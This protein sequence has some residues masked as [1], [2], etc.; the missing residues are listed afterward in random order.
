MKRADDEL[1]AHIKESLTEHEEVYVPGAWERFEKKEGKRAGWAWLT[2]LSAAAAVLLI[3][4]VVFYSNNK[5]LVTQ[6]VQDQ[7]KVETAKQSTAVLP[8]EALEAIPQRTITENLNTKVAENVG[9]VAQRKN[10]LVANSPLIVAVQ[11]DKPVQQAAVSN[12]QPF[13]VQAQNNVVN[14]KPTNL[15]KKND[16]ISAAVDSGS[17]A[18]VL[19]KENT[20]VTEGKTRSFQDF[21]DA[22]VKASSNALA[23]AKPSAKKADKWEMGLVVAPS[24]GNSKKLNMGYG[25]SLGYA[26]SDKVSISSGVSY[27]EMGAS[28]SMTGGGNTY[29]SPT[30]SAMVS[31]TQSLQSVDANVIGIDIPLGIKYNLSKKFYTNVGVS[32]FAVLSQKQ[33]NNYLKGSLEYAVQDASNTLALKTVFTTKSVS[34]P[35]PSAELPNDKYLGF[36]NISFGFKQKLSGSKSFAVEPF[37]K[38]PM[39]EFTKDNL[40]LIGTG[41]RL[42]FDF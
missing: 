17:I 2:S 15:V 9:V 22:E 16:V 26:L 7:A 4:F 31:N 30:T 29:D 33:N 12:E 13:V 37:M 42:K 6:P 20:P 35:V 41:L 1:F 34:E 5:I 11:P 14:A 25:L 27:N 10:N 19:V 8:K 40:N 28:K 36:Y 18:K 21:L 23:S 32:A 38:L 3:G 24:I 39:K